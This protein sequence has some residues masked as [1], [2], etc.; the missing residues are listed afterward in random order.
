[1]LL[2]VVYGVVVVEFDCGVLFVWCGYGCGDGEG[3]Y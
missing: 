2:D 3:I 1:M